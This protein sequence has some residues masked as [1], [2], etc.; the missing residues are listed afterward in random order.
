MFLD[1][2]NSGLEKPTQQS[3]ARIL[4]LPSPSYN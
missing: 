4:R 2:L 1:L 3:N